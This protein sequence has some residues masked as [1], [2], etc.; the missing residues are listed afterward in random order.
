MRLA[1]SVPVAAPKSQKNVEG[2]QLCVDS[3]IVAMPAYDMI[4]TGNDSGLPA[5]AVGLLAR[6]GDA[7]Q[8]QAMLDRLRKQL[9]P[10]SS[11]LVAV[12]EVTSELA[13]LSRQTAV[14]MFA[15]GCVENRWLVCKTTQLL[16]QLLARFPAADWYVR[17]PRCQGRRAGPGALQHPHC[18]LRHI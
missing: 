5:V 17:L 3:S 15:T 16:R 8:V 13:A 6:Q 7:L 2:P 9:V 1:A 12:D 14:A 11:L 10:A 4:V 18:Y